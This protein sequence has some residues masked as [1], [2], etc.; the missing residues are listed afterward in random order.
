MTSKKDKF[1]TLA[2]D[3]VNPQVVGIGSGI[4]SAILAA[5]VPILLEQLTACLAPKARKNPTPE[6]LKAKLQAAYNKD[7]KS[8][9]EQAAKEAMK[10]ARKQGERIT[11]EQAYAI[12]DA[13]IH[14]GLQTPELDWSL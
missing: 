8:V 2:A 11:K 7:P 9:R 4:I 12:G 1:A 10:Q 14:E 5:I 6:A 3:R 13:A